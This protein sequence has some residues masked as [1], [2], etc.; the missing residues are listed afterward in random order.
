MSA[1]RSRLDKIEFQLQQIIEGNTDRLFGIH[2]FNQRLANQLVR[3]LER[4]MIKNPAGGFFAPSYFSMLANQKYA[5]EIA[6]NRA[7]MQLI[8]N[9]LVKIANKQNIIFTETPTISIYSDRAIPEGEFEIHVL[10]KI[11]SEDDAAATEE[12]MTA[13]SANNNYSKSNHF[14]ILEDRSVQNL[15]G[16][17][18]N[19]GRD[20]DNQFVIDDMRVS[21]KHAQL[22]IKN[23]HLLLSDLSSSGGT[24]V[25]GLDITQV[26]LSAGD[27]VSFGG[28]AV[29]YGEDQ[30]IQLSETKEHQPVSW[31]YQDS[32]NKDSTPTT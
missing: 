32:N 23:G 25:N 28:F 29:V 2:S 1:I 4:N 19:I 8:S 6:N 20:L 11:E 30:P 10:H 7:L 18:I 13:N 22:R 16:D 31:T 14:F 17:I 9:N 24:S 26:T 15:D 27:V 21:R 5:E 12:M 3:A